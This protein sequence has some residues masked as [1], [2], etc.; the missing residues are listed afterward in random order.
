V[1]KI[2]GPERLRALIRAVADAGM[3]IQ[4]HCDFV[5]VEKLFENAP[6]SKGIWAHS[7]FCD[8]LE[9]IGRTM[10]KYKNV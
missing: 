3:F 8:P 5:V 10:D 9:I 7:G 1:P 6:N 2:L 4:F